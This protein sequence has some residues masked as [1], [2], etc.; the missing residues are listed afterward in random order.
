MSLYHGERGCSSHSSAFSCLLVR[1]HSVRLVC[2][3][4][5][6]FFLFLLNV[7]FSTHVCKH[8]HTQ[9]ETGKSTHN[10]AQSQAHI[11]AWKTMV[12]IAVYQYATLHSTAHLQ[13]MCLC[14]YPTFSQP[15]PTKNV[16]I[17]SKI[18]KY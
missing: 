4:Y 12:Y 8:S 7:S 9:R 14:K 5:N 18:K 3:V 16:K 2:S 15:S 1:V 6:A 10:Y 13:S 17:L 11:E